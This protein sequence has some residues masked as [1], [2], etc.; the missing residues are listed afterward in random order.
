MQVGESAAPT[1]Q[2]GAAALRSTALTLMGTAGI[3]AMDVLSAALTQVLGLAGNA[4]LRIETEQLPL[5]EVEAAWGR[6][7]SSRRLVFRP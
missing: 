5:S 1:I 3:P 2:L 7:A 6:P 4:Q